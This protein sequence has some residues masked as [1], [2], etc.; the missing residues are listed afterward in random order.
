MATNHL[1]E[2]QANQNQ[3]KRPPVIRADEPAKMVDGEEPPNQPV[4]VKKNQQLVHDGI[5]YSE[6]GKEWK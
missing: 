3:R 2:K 4:P 5:D 6:F 1:K